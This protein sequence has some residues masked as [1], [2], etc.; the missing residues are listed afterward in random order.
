ME[1]KMSKILTH[2]GGRQSEFEIEEACKQSNGRGNCGAHTW[3]IKWS[4]MAE[5]RGGCQGEDNA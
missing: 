1:L 4:S 3:R 2:V 5:I